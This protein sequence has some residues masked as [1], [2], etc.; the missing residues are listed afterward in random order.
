[1]MNIIYSIILTKKLKVMRNLVLV[2]TLLICSWNLNAQNGLENIIVEKYYISDG[3]DTIANLDGG[4][5]PVGSVTYRVYV[6]MLPGY[7]FQVCYGVPTHELRIET[8]TLFFNNED[9][10]STSPN[11]SF[12]N[13]AKNTV[14]LDSWLSVGAACNG[15]MGIL[16]SDDNGVGNIVNNY[17]PQVLQNADPAAGIPLTQQDGLIAGTPE[18][19]TELGITNELAVFDNQN[20]GTN[21]PV[22]STLNGSWVA[23]NGTYGPDTIENKVLI[24]QITTDGTFCFQMNI[25]LRTPTPGIVENYV[26]LNPTGAEILFPGLNYCSTTGSPEFTVEG[27]AFSVYPNPSFDLFSMWIFASRQSGHYSYRIYSLDGKQ[28][29]SKDLGVQQ[30]DMMEKIDLTS[31]AAGVYMVELSLNGQTTTRR[32]VKN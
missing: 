8:T 10:G 27:P 15:Y 20:D 17:T 32:V 4:V 21:G 24:A 23:L 1:M 2:F 18:A 16:K 22:F 29:F 19:F 12:T 6:D 14:M 31:F 26:A 5:L 7:K 3:N 30:Q 28:M 25:Q 11:F 13:A 9:R